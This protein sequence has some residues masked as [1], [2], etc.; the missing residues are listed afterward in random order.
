MKEAYWGYWLIVLGVFIIFVLLLVQ[1]FTSTN[2]Q[3]Y[4]LVKEIT[5]AAM[6]DSVDMAYYSTYGEVK[7]NKEKF[8]ESFIIRFADEASIATTYDIEFTD[9]Y[10]APPKVGVKVSSKGNVFAI[11]GSSDSFD[12]VNK[13]DAIMEFADTNTKE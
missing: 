6:L 12:I 9:M 10:E 7:I 3:D 8:Y 5:E 11:A 1:N 2:S 13:I 4:Y